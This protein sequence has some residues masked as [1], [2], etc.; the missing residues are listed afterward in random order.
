MAKKANIFLKV[1]V[2]GASSGSESEIG[3]CSAES[4][5]GHTVSQGRDGHVSKYMDGDKPGPALIIF[6]APYNSSSPK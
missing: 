6:A 2:G 3:L 1:M 4:N 5:M